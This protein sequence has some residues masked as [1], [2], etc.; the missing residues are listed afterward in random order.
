MR[1]ATT[2]VKG[3]TTIFIEAYLI[4]LGL[5]LESYFT[6]YPFL[7]LSWHPTM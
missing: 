7:E 6:T 2:E 5:A 1:P 3:K 4:G